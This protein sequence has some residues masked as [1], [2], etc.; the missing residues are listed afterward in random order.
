VNNLATLTASG[1]AGFYPYYN[2][3]FTCVTPQTGLSIAG[4]FYVAGSY[5][6]SGDIA[7][8]TGS[9]ITTNDTPATWNNQ[10][11][12]RNSGTFYSVHGGQWGY[13]QPLVLDGV[14]QPTKP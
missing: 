5:L 1:T 10:G 6:F 12:F 9:L 14:Q 11:T 13:L 2:Q 7:V 4:R 8:T 3:V